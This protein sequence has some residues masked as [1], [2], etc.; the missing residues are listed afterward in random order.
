MKMKKTVL[1]VLVAAVGCGALAADV[2]VKV[3]GTDVSAGTGDGWTYEQE[4]RLLTLSGTG[5][6]TLSGTNKVGDVSV[7]QAASSTVILSDLVLETPNDV[8]D[9]LR[10]PYMV[11]TGNSV[12]EA[13]ILLKG[14]SSIVSGLTWSDKHNKN[15]AVFVSYGSTLTIDTENG[16][17]NASLTAQ[18]APECPGIG[19]GRDFA[20]GTLIIDGGRITAKAGW[21]GACIGGG[22]SWGED[23]VCP[24]K[25]V[26]NGGVI[27]AETDCDYGPEES[28]AG[29]GCPGGQLPE[30][31][32][33]G[34]GYDIVIN[35]G[36]IVAKSRSA[37]GDL[38]ADL[39][40]TILV[41]G[42]SVNGRVALPRDSS[43]NVLWRVTIEGVRGKDPVTVEGLDGYGVRDVRP[44]DGMLSFW[45]PNGTYR[46]VVDGRVYTATVADADV[47]ASSQWTVGDGVSAEWHDRILSLTGSGKV[48]DY[49]SAAEL[50]WAGFTV[51]NMTFASGV[52][53]GRNTYAGLADTAMVNGT[54][55]IS[56][57]RAS[58]GE[59][60]VGNLSPAE[61]S[62][63][64]IENGE[65][66]LTVVVDESADLQ[67]WTPAKT[68]DLTVPV[69]DEKGFYILR[70]K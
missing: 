67:T 21:C 4:K 53:P 1:A 61:A 37:I 26:I 63:L 56:L 17:E 9:L 16:D 33:E 8:G 5:T 46:L 42:G 25:I 31:G 7:V 49:A 11:G 52:T 48:S 32:R 40:R 14:D 62:A 36:T 13:K 51:T 2:G 30:E 19:G 18:G 69:K 54:V 57:L 6:F 22:V 58:A 47:T 55:P 64:K 60:L 29:I 59:F 3:N 50:P 20:M 34:L 68:V 43:G 44:V 45:L 70:S 10:P 27:Y 66:K 41:K 38:I 39:G 28:P 65:V 15:A 24:G 23:G 35:G 12:V